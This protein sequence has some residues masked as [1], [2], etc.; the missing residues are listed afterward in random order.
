M[1]KKWF[2]VEQR[3]GQHVA[4]IE[5]WPGKPSVSGLSVVGPFTRL[6]AERVA[7]EARNEALETEQ[8]VLRGTR[9]A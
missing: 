5:A 8:L 2:V 4:W 7:D 6:V 9:I 1:A 3:S